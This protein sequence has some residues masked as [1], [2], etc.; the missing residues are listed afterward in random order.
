MFSRLLRSLSV[1]LI[2]GLLAFGLFA[3]AAHQGPAVAALLF[4]SLN[5]GAAG[6]LGNF[7]AT[8][9][10]NSFGTLAPGVLSMSMLQRLQKKYPPVNAFA[11]DFSD[12]TAKFG[13]AITARVAVKPTV[14]DYSA[15]N[16]YVAG[17]AST[18]DVPVTINKHKHV[19]LSF[20]SEEISGTNR[21]LTE[22]QLDGCVTAIGE[23]VL[24][25][26]FALVTLG[27]FTTTPVTE[28]INN[29]DR[30]TLT[31]VRK[32]LTGA[33][34]GY[35][36]NGFVSDEA[37]EK[38]TNDAKIISSDYVKTD[39]DY[40]GGIIT[41]VAGFRQ[42]FE[43]PDL[44]N[45]S[46]MVGFYCNPAALVLAT[47]LPDDPASLMADLGVPMTGVVVP[48]KDPK[49]GL[50]LLLRYHYNM[51]RGVLQMDLV[52]MYGVALGVVGHGVI[53]ITS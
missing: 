25:D 42:I 28:T 50:T 19:S 53:V 8:C 23:Q 37:F 31:A 15:A 39:P 48:V 35:P 2:V 29:H 33:G 36:R 5:V 43:Y 20:N 14:S 18:T 13:E 9:R 45:T 41:N 11:T 49:T 47:R 12:K 16:G 30:E 6:L 52:I 1:L 24:S 51:Q 26:L 7:S 10:A 38:I 40:E 17:N 3:V 27:N 4:V 22:E 34:A 44:P 21:K 46:N 32:A